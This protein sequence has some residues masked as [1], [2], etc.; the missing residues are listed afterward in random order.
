MSGTTKGAGTLTTKEILGG[1]S[2]VQYVHLRG[3]LIR[4][5]THEN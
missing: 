1:A 4:A 3:A 5:P 2:Y